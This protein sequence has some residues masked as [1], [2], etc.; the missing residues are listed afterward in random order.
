[1]KKIVLITLILMCCALA[2]VYAGGG[3]DGASGQ[4]T[5]QLNHVLP[6]AHSVHTSMLY[7]SDI[8]KERSGGRINIEVFPSST[9]GT[10]RESQEALMAGTLDMAIVTYESIMVAVPEIGALILPF[11]YDSYEHGDRV[12]AGPAGQRAHEIILQ[13]ANTK[14][15]SHYIQAFRQIFSQRSLRN[16]ADIAG[17]RIRVPES[18]LY[19]NTFTLLGAAPTPVAWAEAYSALDTGVVQAIENT[20]E[21]IYSMAMHEVTTHMNLTDHL[22]APTT[23]SMA[24]RVWERQTAEIQR[25]LLETAAMAGAF[26]LKLTQEND[27]IARRQLAERLQIVEV[28]VNSYR[29]RMDYNRFD[30][31]RIP[32]AQE[33]KALI[34]ATR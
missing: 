20:P 15:L 34:D 33:I 2:G 22:L 27:A 14:V 29:S 10:E 32:A 9:L 4:L 25:I 28:D 13:R 6:P 21:A 19:V 24:G 30:I 26:A 3:S 1:M 31:M 8:A 18:P 16:A 12:F 23:I 7:F 5:F 11:M 17:I